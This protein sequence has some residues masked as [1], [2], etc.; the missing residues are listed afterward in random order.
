MELVLEVLQKRRGA[1]REVGKCIATECYDVRPEDRIGL[2]QE[3]QREGGST[4]TRDLVQVNLLQELEGDA[5]EVVHGDGGRDGGGGGE[6]DV[7][8]VPGDDEL[9]DLPPG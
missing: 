1:Y 7:V 9:L 3:I 4:P 8:H 5:A 6:V 2:E